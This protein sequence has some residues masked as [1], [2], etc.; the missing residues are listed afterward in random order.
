MGHDFNLAGQESENGQWLCSTDAMKK[1]Q[2]IKAL[3]R[4]QRQNGAIKGGKRR[5]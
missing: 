3:K 1:I 5:T 4:K 2:V